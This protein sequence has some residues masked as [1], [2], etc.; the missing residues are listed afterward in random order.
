MPK[1][2]TGRHHRHR[3]CR[4]SRRRPHHTVHPRSGGSRR[5]K[6]SRV[7]R[8]TTRN[9]KPPTSRNLQ[10]LYLEHMQNAAPGR[11]IQCHFDTMENT[12]HRLE[13]I[14]RDIVRKTQPELVSLI[15]F[16][17]HRA[18]KNNDQ[19]TTPRRKYKVI[20]PMSQGGPQA[21]INSY[22]AANKL[23]SGKLPRI[24]RSTSRDRTKP[25]Q[26]HLRGKSPRT[27][28]GIKPAPPDCCRRSHRACIRLQPNGLAR[29][30][31]KPPT[32]A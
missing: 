1:T 18:P 21:A 25:I 26:R 17:A 22:V 19:H 7:R 23:L 24:S 31:D 15:N 30:E 27:A 32:A 10:T 12:R 4:A 9:R 3:S 2:S 20:D 6:N 5:R 16:Q 13:E 28:D 14:Y 8:R 11:W 29:A